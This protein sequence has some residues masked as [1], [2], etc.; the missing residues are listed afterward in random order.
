M[1]RTA[2]K[3]IQIINCT[4]MHKLFSSVL[5]LYKSCRHIKYNLLFRGYYESKCLTNGLLLVLRGRSENHS[6][7]RKHSNNFLTLP[8]GVLG[9]SY[10]GTSPIRTGHRSKNSYRDTHTQRENRGVRRSTILLVFHIFP[11]CLHK[12][13]SFQK[14]AQSQATSLLLLSA[15]FI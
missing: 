3:A 14:Q 15:L 9:P 11:H 8:S 13:H 12:V 1:Q 5:C 7:N 2:H 6:E 10:G 4:E